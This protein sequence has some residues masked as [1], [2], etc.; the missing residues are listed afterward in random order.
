MA[1]GYTRLVS[2]SS[3]HDG[4]LYCLSDSESDI[5]SLVSVSSNKI[6][7]PNQ[8]LTS[9]V[10]FSANQGSLPCIAGGESNDAPS[11]IKTSQ[12][13]RTLSESDANGK[14]GFVPGN[15]DSV[16]SDEITSLAHTRS[17]DKMSNSSNAIPLLDP[18]PDRKKVLDPIYL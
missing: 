18:P 5:K 2:V 15:D 12:K 10:K 6:A 13:V 1:N 8:Q 4:S 9:V 3:N 11:P 14:L 17:R 16:L 7:S